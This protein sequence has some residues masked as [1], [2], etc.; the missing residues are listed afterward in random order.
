MGV[1]MKTLIIPDVHEQWEVLQ[2]IIEQPIY[3]EADEIVYT[4]DVLDSYDGTVNDAE[5]TA[6]IMLQ[7]IED[8]RVHYLFGNHDIQYSIYSHHQMMCDN[9]KYWKFD[10]F[11]LELKPLWLKAKLF[12]MSQGWLMSHAGIASEF[13]D[14]LKIGSEEYYNTLTNQCFTRLK[15]KEMHYLVAAGEARGGRK[16][17]VGGVTW[18]DWN[19]EFTPIPGLNQIVG[20]TR[21]KEVR[22]KVTDN[23]KN[24]CLDCSLTRLG[25][26]LDGN[27]KIVEVDRT[28]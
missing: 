27:L 17:Q 6:E 15:S 13:A 22:S 19:S 16:G 9:A 7:Q 3:K 11:P 21:G 23:S 24:V 2:G 5:R 1:D 10:R 14:P 12:H 20:H 4:G 28:K 8:P 25:L 18:L 26:I